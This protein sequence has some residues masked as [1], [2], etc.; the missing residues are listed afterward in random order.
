VCEIANHLLFT[1]DAFVGQQEGYRIK[2]LIGIFF[3]QRFY[4]GQ[5]A[6]G[7]D[8]EMRVS[9]IA[10]TSTQTLGRF[11]AGANIVNGGRG[12]VE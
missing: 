11:N 12:A 6:Q 9:C 10:H 5:A 2:N 3:Q 1:V 8:F 4:Q 7:I